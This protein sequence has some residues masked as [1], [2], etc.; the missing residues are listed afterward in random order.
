MDRRRKRRQHQCQLCFRCTYPEDDAASVKHALAH[1]SLYAVM[2]GE[3]CAPA[4][5]RTG[6]AS[7]V[8]ELERLHYSYLN[9][10]YHPDVLAGWAEQGCAEAIA[11]RLGYRL[12]LRQA[13]L[14]DAV[15]PGGRARVSLTLENTGFAAPFRARTVY[16]VLRDSAGAR[17]TL[18]LNQ[19]DPRRWWPGRHTMTARI[20]W[21][22]QAAPGIA[23]LSLWLPDASP[24][25]A[26]RPAYAIRLANQGTWRRAFG[27]NV[28]GE[29]RI[30]ETAPGVADTRQGG[31]RL[32][33]A[34][35]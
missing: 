14:P 24:S 16:L 27:D 3:T 1:E 2:G 31:W 19:V 13:A 32:L 18:P 7:A 4:G 22:A 35:K 10:G 26:A 8:R 12:A 17:W 21:P 28:L 15:R 6:C 30:S 20:A 23:T 9:F 29:V 33:P 25:L 34:L 5:Q 11:E